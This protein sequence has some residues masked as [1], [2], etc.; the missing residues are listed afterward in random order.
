MVENKVYICLFTCAATRAVHLEVVTDLT[1]ATFLEAFR[2]FV[3][4]KS[5]PHTIIASTYHL[6]ADELIQLFESISLKESL[7]RQE[8]IWQNVDHGL[9]GFGN[10]LLA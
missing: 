1:E 5:L 3:G 10:A 6:E 2:R 4:C 7:D 8:V 9:G